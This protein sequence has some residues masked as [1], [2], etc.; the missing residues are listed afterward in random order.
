MECER[1]NNAPPS[2]MHECKL[3]HFSRV[4]LFATPWTIAHKVPLSM[5]FSRQ[6]NWGGLSYLPPGALPKPGI[7]PASPAAPILQSDSLLLSHRGSPPLLIS[8]THD[9][10]RLQGKGELRWQL[11]WTWWGYPR[12]SRWNQ[13]KGRQERSLKWCAGERNQLAVTGWLWRQKRKHKQANAGGL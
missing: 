2:K 9:D 5:G 1:Q 8:G 12:F 6:E 7:E 13:P 10:V 11:T 4:W 3:S